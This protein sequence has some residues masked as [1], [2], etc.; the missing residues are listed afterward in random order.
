MLGRVE[1]VGV[2]MMFWDEWVRRGK[3]VDGSRGDAIVD[4][5]VVVGSIMTGKQ[6]FE[7]TQ[8]ESGWW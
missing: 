2:V 1:E 8:A 4:I 7:R 5:V 3:G 6:R